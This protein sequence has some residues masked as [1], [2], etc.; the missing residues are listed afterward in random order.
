[1]FSRQKTLFSYREDLSD[2]VLIDRE[3]RGVSGGGACN[4]SQPN[5]CN[6]NGQCVNSKCEC[7]SGHADPVCAYGRKSRLT[8]FLLAFFVGS[9]GADRFYL[10]Y[11]G[12]GV[13][14]I[15][16]LVL[17]IL[18]CCVSVIAA[19][20]VGGCSAGATA[21][22]GWAAFG[23]IAVIPFVFCALVGFSSIIAS[24]VWWLV[25]WIL[26]LERNLNDYDGYS[27]ED[28]F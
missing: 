17:G 18:I 23:F 13:G 11:I 12:D 25:D 10:G 16:L 27:L 28:D 24:V 5:Q 26:I 8:A 2:E 20:V 22:T 15:L 14:K 3:K 21:K 9:Y 1:M 4:A 6:N 19:A 7:D